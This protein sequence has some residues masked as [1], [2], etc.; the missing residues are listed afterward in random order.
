M[1]RGAGKSVGEGTVGSGSDA[2]SGALVRAAE[3]GGAGSGA[4]SGFTKSD[5]SALL[6]GEAP[7]AGQQPAH[8][9]PWTKSRRS[10]RAPGLSSPP[11]TPA[12]ALLPEARP[13]REQPRIP[14]VPPGWRGALDTYGNRGSRQRKRWCLEGEPDETSEPTSPRGGAE[15]AGVGT[16]APSWH[17]HGRAC[18][19]RGRRLEGGPD[20]TSRANVPTRRG[21][22]G[23]R[24][25]RR[26]VLARTRA[27][28]SRTWLAPHTLPSG[29]PCC[30]TWFSEPR[31]RQWEELLKSA[32]LTK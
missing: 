8:W 26:P 30:S 12:T 20:E 9:Q 27:R 25:H 21:R 13:R 7:P 1:L 32:Q 2:R 28:M 18:P 6:S 16:G 3:T 14:R 23:R 4:L 5:L 29:A 19:A 24:G 31:S 10:V 15:R 22:A 11:P 17:A